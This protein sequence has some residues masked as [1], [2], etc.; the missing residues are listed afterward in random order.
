MVNKEPVNWKTLP[1]PPACLYG[2]YKQE[3]RWLVRVKCLLNERAIL[4]F[5]PL[6]DNLPVKSFEH[7]PVVCDVLL[8]G[9]SSDG[10]R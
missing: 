3:V 4:K 5:N 7:T 1:S 8:F 2:E 6:L 10:S 9:C